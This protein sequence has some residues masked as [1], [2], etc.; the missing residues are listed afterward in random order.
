MRQTPVVIPI[1]H[2]LS[3][4]ERKALLRRLLLAVVS[5]AALVAVL[6]AQNSRGSLRGTVQ[7]VIDAENAEE[8]ASRVTGVVEV[9][10]ELEVR[11][12]AF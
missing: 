9:L 11:S 1:T 2:C 3:A 4:K 6:P 5:V 10:E 12:G 8:V 7:D